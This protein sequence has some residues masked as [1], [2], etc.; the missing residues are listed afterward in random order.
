MED[1]CVGVSNLRS[2]DLLAERQEH[3]KAVVKRPVQHLPFVN[4]QVLAL[5]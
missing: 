5:A 3:P 4:H 1:D 2:R